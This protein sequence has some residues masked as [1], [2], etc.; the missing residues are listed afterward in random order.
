MA[1]ATPTAMTQ[2]TT[3]PRVTGGVLI[4]YLL[5]LLAHAPLVY[6]HLQQLWSRPHYQFFPLVLLASA[7][8]MIMRA[9]SNNV[10]WHRVTRWSVLL[11]RGFL[12]AST[13]L[14]T[15]AFLRL[16]PLGAYVSCLLTL[17][18]MILRL[19]LPAWGP[20]SLL[21]LLIRVPYGQDV[22]LIQWMQRVTT[23][24]SSTA[25][26]TIHVEHI[27][28][29][30]ILTFP[31]R[32]LFV[33]EACSGVVSM[34]AIVACAGILAVWWKRSLLHGVT[35]IATGLFWAGAMNVVRVVMIAIALDRYGIDL[36]E[37]WRHEAVGL[38]VFV[39]SLVAL[40]S[41][42]R[43]L[44]F[45]L[46]PVPMNPLAGYWPYAEE[47]WLVRL[48]N[49]CAGAESDQDSFDAYGDYVDDWA[50][51]VDEEE[52]T[53][54]SRVG[55]VGRAQ[56]SRLAPRPWEWA[57]ALL[58]LL[59]GSAQV[60]AGIGPFSIA[61]PVNPSALDLAAEDLPDT[62]AGW[63]Q[64]DFEEQH[65]DT[66]SV[67]GEHSRLWTYRN[68][69]FLVRLSVDFVFPEWHE[70][71]ACYAGTGWTI[72]SRTRSDD[73]STRMAAMLTKPNGE[74]AFLLFDLFDSDGREYVS[75]TGSF[76]H[77]QLRRIFGG[78][79]TRFTLPAYYQVQ[80]LA[81]VPGTSLSEDGRRAMTDLFIEF[82]EHIRVL[83][84]GQGAVGES[85]DLNT[86]S[87]ELEIQEAQ[88][89]AA[90][91]QSSHVE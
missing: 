39:V 25:L 4:P 83:V 52:S 57:F 8:I 82:E 85:D 88:M 44:L 46:A 60:Y 54:T 18:A 9:R 53:T 74:Q 1:T 28:E 80:A 22:A 64:I 5:I 59:I 15:L 27:A 68:G 35:L 37:G 48:W 51:P 67:F 11:S 19:G 14:L 26:D 7:S 87:G 33:E 71:T 23:Q 29:G 32:S 81:G 77:P 12:L 45:L 90:E 61:P 43:L 56:P 69:P 66:S 72:D 86:D 63:K 50:D 76:M 20:W 13:V 31:G 10:A 30:N 91:G 73:D 24:L 38:C 78:E 3:A 41:T 40:F 6:V 36:T 55:S 62:L 17:A 42:D 79:A 49:A 2:E 70:L 47:N 58:F 34:L 65:R 89:K 84:A 21:L 75:P 16:S